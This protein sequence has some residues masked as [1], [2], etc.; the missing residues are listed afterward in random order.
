MFTD[1]DLVITAALDNH[2][3]AAAFDD[4][5]GGSESGRAPAQDQYRLPPV[6]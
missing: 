5:Q 6:T 1:A 3:G 2:R 4:A